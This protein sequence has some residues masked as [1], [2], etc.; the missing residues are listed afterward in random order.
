MSREALVERARREELP[1]VS[2]PVKHYP[3]SVLCSGDHRKPIGLAGCV[4]LRWLRDSA[5]ETEGD[6][7]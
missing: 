1:S 6:A 7:K 4:C 2:P 3:H 5:R